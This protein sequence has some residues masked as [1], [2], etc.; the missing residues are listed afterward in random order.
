MPANAGAAKLCANVV[1]VPQLRLIARTYLPDLRPRINMNK[2]LY[3]DIFGPPNHGYGRPT[4]WIWAPKSGI[5][6]P[7]SGIWTPKPRIWASQSWIWAHILDLGAQIPDLGAQIQDV[8]RRS[9]IWTPKCVLKVNSS[10]F[11]WEFEGEALINFRWGVWGE[12]EALP[13][14]IQVGGFGGENRS[15]SPTGLG[16]AQGAGG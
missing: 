8:G 12:G 16:G 1:S 15:A 5:C 2:N 7:T 10:V 3:G 9:M 11:I 14:Q 4:S 6:A 13:P